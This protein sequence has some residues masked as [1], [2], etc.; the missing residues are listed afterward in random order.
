MSS[1]L[2]S[3][4]INPITIFIELLYVF[5]MKAI[6]N[7]G[8]AIAGVSVAVQLLT[9]PLYQAAD[10]LQREER[11]T[12][13][14]LAPGIERIKSVFKGDERFMIM[15]T[16]Y[17]QNHYHPVYALRSSLSLLIQ[18]PFF[19]AAYHL[20]SH[21]EAL[22]GVRFLLIPDLGVPD[23]M[24]LLG[25]VT[26]N[27]L[28]FLM[29]AINLVSGMLYTK[30]FPLRDKVQVYGVALV[31][32]ILLYNAPAGLVYYWTLNNLFSLGRNLFQRLKRPLWTFYGVS[33][34]VSVAGTIYIIL[35]NPSITL[36]KA[37]FVIVLALGICLIPLIIVLAKSVYSRFLVGL[38]D[39]PTLAFSLFVLS[40]AILWLLNGLLIPSNLISSSVQE[41]SGMGEGQNPLSFIW[42]MAL[43][44]SGI[45][46]FWPI[47]LFR[48]SG[49]RIRVGGTLTFFVLSISSLLN[50]FVFKS[51]YGV[52]NPLLI[53]ENPGLLKASSLNS[54]I[55]LS[56]L[57][58]LVGFSVWRIS[59]KK[60]KEL[61][62][63]AVIVIVAALLASA[64][65][66]FK[67]SSEYREY[68]TIEQQSTTAGQSAN[69]HSPVIHL[70]QEGENVIVLMLD[71]SINS[72]FPMIMEQFPDL[73]EQFSG[74]T[75]FPNTVS[76]G[77]G[78]LTGSPAL[79]GGYEYTPRKINE[80]SDEALV[81][82]HN[83][84]TMVL[85]KIFS[86]AGYSV[87][88]TDPPLA[89][90]AW[91]G[92]F[93]PFD[94]FPDIEVIHQHGQYS[95]RYKM[96]HSDDFGEEESPE[97]ILKKRLPMFSFMTSAF[98][99]LREQMYDT[100]SYLSAETVKGNFDDF[101]SS[102]AQIYYLGDAT[103]Y[104]GTG[105]TYT[106]IDNESTH[107]PVYLR[108]PD[109]LPTSFLDEVYNPFEG[110]PGI[111]ERDIGSYH[112]NAASLKRIGV[113]LDTLKQH[114]IYDTT[115]IIIAADHGRDVYIPPFS[116]FSSNSRIYGDYNP[117]F[118]FKDFNS[119][120]DLVTDPSFMTN[121]D[122]PILALQ[123]LGLDSTNPFTGNDILA[124]VQKDSVEVFKGPWAP[125]PHMGNQF[126][127][128]YARS[129]RVH[130]DIFIESNWELL[131]PEDDR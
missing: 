121:A 108:Y 21:L 126:E 49:K 84:A 97:T 44:F 32:L 40:A 73:K 106:F 48:I 46:L 18:V 1:I 66:V 64:W 65:N 123:G 96:E 56:A 95:L 107:E 81:D 16:F 8:L 93:R 11:N 90:Y 77:S 94:I 101:L 60:A 118:L 71:R 110:I 6:S 38:E 130:D 22:H 131:D 102:F 91:T 113:W 127:F 68:Q 119:T 59:R 55:S 120:G 30:G 31:F 43:V 33:A 103:A 58:L 87:L 2:F 82:K 74:F 53:F 47:M 51:E 37:L 89:N 3:I 29:T 23:G 109:F 41:F 62:H 83:E 69:E 57:A 112:V 128:D 34:L 70:S 114:G 24:L 7:E 14:A 50:I 100:G 111:D 92:D 10:R 104:D 17:R 124:Q 125:R 116:E 79:M 27:L 19:I 39:A 45:F 105:N 75:Y 85:P 13:I 76:S 78:T 28:P 4:I 54:I 42:K 5:F 80:R 61:I 86:S 67:I 88:V 98:P 15:S 25:G 63:V 36:P 99:F 129:F 117:L 9:M 20:I 122:T 52:V 72:Y 35:T 26:V 115:R 12:R